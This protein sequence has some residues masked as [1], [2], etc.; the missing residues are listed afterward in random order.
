MQRIF[1]NTKPSSS[2]PI[3]KSVSSPELSQLRSPA[4]SIPLEPNTKIDP[5]EDINPL[6]LY[7]PLQFSEDFP[8]SQGSNA[9]P[10]SMQS[11]DEVSS[12]YYRNSYSN[13]N[14]LTC[15]KSKIY[16]Q[17]NQVFN[18]RLRDIGDNE[19]NSLELKLVAYQEWL[20]V[21][22]QIYDS[23]I[24]HIEELE[25]KMAE[26]L[27]YLRHNNYNSLVKVVYYNDNWDFRGLSLETISGVTDPSRETLR[28]DD[29]ETERKKEPA[30]IEIEQ[31][32]KDINIKAKM[33]IKKC[34]ENSQKALSVGR[35]TVQLLLGDIGAQDCTGVEFKLLKSGIGSDFSLQALGH[36]S[37]SRFRIRHELRNHRH[38]HDQP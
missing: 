14:F 26:R 2:C 23:A 20:D 4:H 13:Y 38:R 36:E 16:W 17:M 18:K 29:E 6:C 25:T 37:G 24:T 3:I 15:D 35:Q 27:D 32:Y 8:D 5:Q 22:L 34:K 1:E 28:I 7:Q 33:E 21:L 19:E 30:D 9:A 10:L 11:L 31:K 12:D